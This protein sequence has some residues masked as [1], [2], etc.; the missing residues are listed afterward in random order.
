MEFT[1]IPANAPPPFWNCV[2]PTS[3]VLEGNC[4]AAADVV[5]FNEASMIFGGAH[6]GFKL[7]PK[8][9]ANQTYVFYAHEAA[10]TF[11]GEMRDWR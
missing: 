8:K 4:A 11:G 6:P 10:G 7:P 3:R 5:I 2:V 1:W 9:H